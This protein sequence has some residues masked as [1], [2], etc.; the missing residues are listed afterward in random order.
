MCGE[1]GSNFVATDSRLPSK[2]T[3]LTLCCYVVCGKGKGSRCSY[4]EM[5][6]C[7]ISQYFGQTPVVVSVHYSLN[8]A[9]ICLG[10]AGY[11]F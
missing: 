4:S 2:E 3:K 1:G 9:H 11:I 7:T 10:N 5:G 8:S 6:A